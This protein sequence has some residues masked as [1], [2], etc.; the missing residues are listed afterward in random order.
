MTFGFLA[1]E[2]RALWLEGLKPLFIN[3]SSFW[4]NHLLKLTMVMVMVMMGAGR[5]PAS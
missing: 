3:Q 1:Y 4:S 5:G 2:E